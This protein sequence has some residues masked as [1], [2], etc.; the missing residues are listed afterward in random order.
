MEEDPFLS[1]R[2]KRLFRDYLRSQKLIKPQTPHLLQDVLLFFLLF[3]LLIGNAPSPSLAILTVALIFMLIVYR[4]YLKRERELLRLKKVCFQ[5]I[6]VREYQKR[7]EK[8]S[9]EMLLD[10][11]QKE[12]CRR[13]NLST[14]KLNHGL[15]EGRFWGEKIAVAYLDVDGEELV[16]RRQVLAVVRKCLGQG[17]TQVRIFTNGE[18]SITQADFAQYPELNLRLYNGEKLQYLLRN[19]ALFPSVSQIKEIISSEMCKQQKKLTLIQ[20][21]II[22]KKKYAGYFFYSLLLFLMVWLE[23]GVVYLN[24]FAGIII[25]G[26]AVINLIRNLSAREIQPEPEA[27]FQKE[28]F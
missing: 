17:I 28:G 25:L 21:G 16:S 6:A 4:R 2:E 14:L 20:K 19:T 12:L 23:V 8:I 11:L 9:A 18:F 15:L 10:I 1:L 5:K 3:G 7:L 27:Y 26:F 24:L 22:K 13:F